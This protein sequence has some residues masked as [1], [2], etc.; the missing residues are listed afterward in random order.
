[1]SRKHNVKH[2]RSPSRYYQRGTGRPM[3]LISFAGMATILGIPP[4]E[5]GRLCARAV[6]AFDEKFGRKGRR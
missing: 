6:E 4:G 5:Y 2:H 3:P 1:M